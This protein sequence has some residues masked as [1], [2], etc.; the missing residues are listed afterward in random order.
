LFGTVLADRPMPAKF[1]CGSRKQYGFAEL[2]VGQYKRYSA[3]LQ[4]DIRRIKAAA[5]AWEKSHPGVRLQFEQEQGALCVWR[6]E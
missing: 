2:A 6:T 4:P 3:P 5:K 1:D